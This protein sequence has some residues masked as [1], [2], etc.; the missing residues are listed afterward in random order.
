MTTLALQTTSELKSSWRISTTRTNCIIY[1]P[2]HGVLRNEDAG[3]RE[4]EQ[5]HAQ[6]KRMGLATCTRATLRSLELQEMN[7]EYSRVNH[8]TVL[9][10]GWKTKGQA[11][12]DTRF[13][14]NAEAVSRIGALILQGHFGEQA[15]QSEFQAIEGKSVQHKTVCRVQVAG[16]S[17]ICMDPSGGQAWI[18]PF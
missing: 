14:Q 2:I 13:M 4:N 17:W 7:M 10:N 5:S 16:Q 18:P 12:R 8:N 3:L 15:D 1:S 11:S 9:I 6:M